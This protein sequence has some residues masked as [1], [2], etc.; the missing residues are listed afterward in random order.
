LTGEKKLSFSEDE[1]LRR[2]KCPTTE[3]S[4]ISVGLA[5]GIFFR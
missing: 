3:V 4:A 5:A 1:K 2:E